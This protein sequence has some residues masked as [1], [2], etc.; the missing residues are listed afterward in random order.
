M[1]TASRSNSIFEADIEDFLSLTKNSPGKERAAG[2]SAP[3]LAARVNSFLETQLTSEALL[4]L[5]TGL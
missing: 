4:A 3:R 2:G 1:E 5:R